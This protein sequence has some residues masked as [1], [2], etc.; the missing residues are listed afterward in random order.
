[1]ANQTPQLPAMVTTHPS[2][3]STG[4]SQASAPHPHFAD[5]D[6]CERHSTRLSTLL[7]RRKTKNGTVEE[8]ASEKDERDDDDKKTRAASLAARLHIWPLPAHVAWFI[9]PFKSWTKM[10][11]VLRSALIAWIAMFFLVINPVERY[12]GNASFLVLVF[13]LLQPAELPLTGI[14]ERE[15]FMLLFGVISWAWTCVAIKIS[16]AARKNKVPA[17]QAN[18]RSIFMGEYIEAA[19]SIVCCLFLAAGSPVWLYLKVRF[20]PSPFVF[21]AIIAALA[22]DIF[23]TDIPLF[24]YPNYL[25]GKAVLLPM[26]IKSAVTLIVSVVFFPKSV[27]SLFVDRIVLVLKPLSAAIRAQEEMFKSSP[28]DP[29]FDFLRVR[30]TIGQSERAIPLVA[31]ATRLLSREISFGLA[32]GEDLRTVERHVRA[33]VAPA[34]GWAQYFALLQRDL[35]IGHFTSDAPA[36]EKSKSATHTAPHTAP[37]SRPPSRPPS[38]SAPG[39]PRHSHSRPPS[40]PGTPRLETSTEQGTPHPSRPSSIYRHGHH[41]HHHDRGGRVAALLAKAP[42]YS[43]LQQRHSYQGSGSGP[44]TPSSAARLRGGFFSGHH[45]PDR[46]PVGVWESLRF[47]EIDQRLHTKSADFIT[48]Q[49]FGLLGES[50]E[51]IMEA[52][53]AAL[54]YIVEWLATLNKQRYALLLAR[55]TGKRVEAGTKEG[56]TRKPTLEVIAE[57]EAALDAFKTKERLQVIDLFKPSVEQPGGSKTL[58]HRYLFQAFVHQHTNIVF[59]DRLLVLL[60]YL[61]QLERERSRGRIWWPSWPRFLTRQAW[62]NGLGK[63]KS[64]G[65]AADAR[66]RTSRDDVYHDDDHHP[67]NDWYQSGLGGASPRDPDCLEPTSGMQRLGTSIH[68]WLGRATSG[69]MLFAL[70]VGV[71]TGLVSMPFFFKRSAGWVQKEKGERASQRAQHRDLPLLTL[72]SRAPR[73]LDSLHGPSHLR[74]SSRRL[75]LAARSA[76]S[77]HGSGCN[78]RPSHLVH[79]QRLGPSK[80]ICHDGRVGHRSCAHLRL[81]ALLAFLSADLADYR[82]DNCC[83]AGLLLEGQP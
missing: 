25:V 66:D 23:L 48:D 51:K 40:R 71:L 46:Q 33:L 60:R 57:L 3:G 67:E 59:T 36:Q 28:L 15:L 77:Q 4:S 35:R 8:G 45:T 16:Y 27:N 37:P 70:K 80:S 5:G 42:I 69:N 22:L 65:G 55:F 81:P 43:H 75:Y 20:G 26:A 38:P 10:K 74:P 50:S 19:P 58:P 54:D 49:V 76:N 47:S 1:M 64:R 18:L 9:P 68:R 17:S 7:R 21:S 39:T 78:R 11:P 2:P 62:A 12:L 6:A 63:D 13:A 82:L 44:D 24:P 34:N 31:A 72:F 53:A 52:N 79:L 29:E 73:P 30:T 41:H 56:K 32:S 14:L 83:H 61:E